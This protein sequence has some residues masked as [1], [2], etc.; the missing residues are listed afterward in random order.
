MRRCA[1][2]P[3]H[4]D[5]R[6]FAHQVSWILRDQPQD[7]GQVRAERR[8]DYVH[9]RQVHGPGHA[10][11]PLAPTLLLVDDGRSDHFDIPG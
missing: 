8:V 6:Q 1:P 2:S 4:Q 9:V 11:L 7:D 3:H 5:A 10:G